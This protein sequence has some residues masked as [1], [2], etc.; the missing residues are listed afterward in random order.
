MYKLRKQNIKGI[1]PI[2]IENAK[3]GKVELYISGNYYQNGIPTENNPIEIQTVNQQVNIKIYNQKVYNSSI[4]NSLLGLVLGYKK[5]NG[6]EYILPIQQEMLIEDTFEKDENGN[7]YEVHNW[8]KINSYNNEPINTEFI[9]TTGKLTQG[10]TV[11]YKKDIQ[12]R[13]ECTNEQKEILN[14]FELY[15]GFNYI[16]ANTIN[17]SKPYINFSYDVELTDELK[18]AFLTKIVK[19]YVVRTRDG[20][21]INQ[22]NYLKNF[23]LEDLRFIPDNGF[24]GGTVARRLT[25]D[26]NN[27]NNEFN[28]Q[29]EDLKFYISVEYNN[30]EYFLEYGNFIVQKPDTENTTD[31]TSFEALDYMCK[32]NQ[33]YIDEIKYPCKL[34]ELAENVCKQAGVEL[35]NKDFK[36]ANFIVTDNQ[37]VGGETL[38]VVLGA[39][40]LSAFSFA[41]IG[42]D[43]KVYIDFEKK[44]NS[45]I[46]LNADKYY[47][48]SFA[49][50]EYGP[51]NKIILRNSQ[52]EGENVTIQDDESI[53]KN[54]LHELV[55]SDNPFAYT[56]EKRLQLIEAGREMF[57]FH[58]MPINS[59]NSLGYAFLDSTSLIKIED[60]QGNEIY[61][62]TLNHTIDYDGTILDEIACPA[63]TET[64]TK[65]TYT[66]EIL[67][68]LQKTEFIV[69]KQNQTITGLVTKTDELNTQMTKVEQRV[70]GITQ[71]VQDVKTDLDENYSTTTE[72]NSKI[73]QSAGSIT[74]SVTKTIDNIQIGG[75]NLIPN[76]AP[77]NLE[78]Y[79]VTAPYKKCLNIRTLQQLSQETGIYVTPTTNTL[80]GNKEYC[81]SIWLKATANTSVKVGYAKGGQTTFAV[82]TEWQ[83]FTYK[84]K[85]LEPTNPTHGFTIL[86]PSTTIQGRQILV[87]S[88]KLEEGNKITAWCPAP[89]DDVKG[90]EFG[91]KIIQDW[92]SV[93]IA[94]N[95]ISEYIQFINAMLQIKDTNNNL[96]MALT[97]DGQKIYNLGT[98]FATIG[99][100]NYAKDENQKGLSFGMNTNGRF[101]SW[102]KQSTEDGNYI[103]KLYYCAENS[104]G[105]TKEGIYFGVPAFLSDELNLQSGRI[106]ESESVWYPAVI[107]N[108]NIKDGFVRL[109]RYQCSFD[110]EDAIYVKG[111]QVQT[112]QSDGRLKH[113]IKNTK[114]NALDK[115]KQIKHR[116]FIWNK[117]NKEEHI[118][119]IA[120]ELEK[121]DEN[122]VIKNPQYDENG[123]IIDY[124]YQVNL[125]PILATATK[126]I[127]ELEEKLE[128][129]ESIINKQQEFLFKIA[130]KLNMQNEYNTT[131]NTTTPKMAKAMKIENDEVDYGT[132]IKYSKNSK[133]TTPNRMII[134]KDGIVRKEKE[135]GK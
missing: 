120:Q 50:K 96:L 81:F 110:V 18:N 29:D 13:I 135:D 107:I 126:A 31:N 37:F 64:E 85:A 109:S 100:S 69:D 62:Y 72:M 87:H 99:S 111:Y 46:S 124:L 1:S 41:R 9:S 19:A 98:L 77:F 76:S 8:T 3:S 127:S 36:N 55:I 33:P 122:Y 71:T 58:Y 94:W 106:T 39:I 123:N 74:S 26:F 117:D 25:I 2:I 5:P 119:Y 53:E 32:F 86:L 4:L 101:I 113:N 61:S 131:F 30:V 23:K 63:L 16:L 22:D 35:G 129:K 91:T 84:F 11:Y 121:V 59:M 93:Q 115:I 83:K 52:V 43:N 97:K 20:F 125:L 67:Q 90:F 92:E 48:L 34:I 15:E 45:D 42:Q 44:E 51:I 78:N 73:E 6:K 57:G 89:E 133:A 21:V 108:D 102:G 70:D 17:M 27:V 54:G 132:D 79:V 7:W 10:A 14:S 12:E 130:E 60:M 66:P 82:T 105:R 38:R 134:T 118:G 56:Q 40:A 88:I 47:N 65:Y 49:S 103:A 24:L 28:I 95:Q 75:T 112:N 104:F 128:E 68:K 116:Q 80:E 114:I